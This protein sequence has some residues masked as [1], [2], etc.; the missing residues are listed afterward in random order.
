MKN[1]TL[2]A[3]HNDPA[4]KEKHLACLREHR[5]LELLRPYEG[6][7]G[8]GEK[9]DPICCL[10]QSNDKATSPKLLGIP[11]WALWLVGLIDIKLHKGV[12]DFVIDWVAAIPV[13]A[14][15][16]LARHELAVSRSN[17]SIG[18][19]FFN[20]GFTH[21][22]R[23][24]ITAV[25][26]ERLRASRVTQYQTETAWTEASLTW[27]AWA[28]WRTEMGPKSMWS[29]PQRIS[30]ACSAAHAA[31]EAWKGWNCDT[32]LRSPQNAAKAAAEL[33]G[34]IAPSA[35]RMME[36]EP[37]QRWEAEE[38][39]YRWEGETLLRLTSSIYVPN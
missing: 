21:F 27:A 6:W 1:T 34:E 10:I 29:M 11:E 5:S 14:N 2:R 20:V 3:F 25:S 16:E 39:Q 33:M 7:S 15:L 9:C 26:V 30:V 18:R 17:A 31:Q 22:H 19:L 4:I 32:A 36:A 8:K 12:G 35:D 23:S 37:Q 24:V 28:K 38:Q 13:G